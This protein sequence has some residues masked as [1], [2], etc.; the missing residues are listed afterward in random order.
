M[1]SR[2]RMRL[3]RGLTAVAV[4]VVLFTPAAG[5]RGDEAQVRQRLLDYVDTFNR[6]SLDE[7][8]DYWAE[9]AEHRDRRTGEVTSGREAILADIREA[10]AGRG[11]I[12][13]SGSV[14]DVRLVTPQ[15]AT[16]GGTVAIRTP[17][18]LPDET[19]FHAVLVRDQGVWR[20]DS[21]EETAIARPVSPSERLAA[22][23]WLI[24]NWVDDGG[25]TVVRT[26]ID[27]SPGGAFLVR[28]Y[29]ALGETDEGDIRGTQII[30]WDPRAGHIRSWS[31]NS[32]GS[33]GD[34]IWS[35]SGEGWLIKSTQTLA[36]GRAASGTYVLEPI[37]SDE[38][39]FKLIGH[40]IEG[41]PQP[42]SPAV[43][44]RRAPSAPGEDASRQDTAP[45]ADGN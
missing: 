41:E 10:F 31:F 37:G 25:E 38:L 23:E 18:A 9:N 17:G 34:G 44:I 22:L 36:D 11:G 24:G 35:P 33:F 3:P 30:G 21:I 39:S 40:E 19:G 1:P 2:Y 8:A 14:G 29:V 32:D 13:L 7:L 6:G 5:A 27:W 4:A 45:P 20:F 16:V 28:S 12:R 15:V 43:I 26:M 42:A